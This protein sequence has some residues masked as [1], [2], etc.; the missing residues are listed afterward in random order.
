MADEEVGTKTNKKTQ[1]GRDVYKTSDGEM[2]SEKSITFEVDG[3][4]VNIP[5]IHDGVRYSDDEVYRKFMAGE[6]QP[7]SAHQT[8]EEAITAAKERSK[9]LKF[10]KGGTPMNRQMELFARGGL[11][12]EGGMIDE[13]SGNKVP[14][15]GTR[16]GVRDDIEANVSEGEFIFPEDVTRYI[17]L[18]KLM[19]LRQEAKMGLKR[20][21]A[22][23]Q[24]GNSDEA[25]MDD[26]LPFGMDD[27]IIVAGDSGNDGELNMAVG[28]LTTGTTNVTRTPDPVATVANNPVLPATTTGVRRLTPEI[29]QPVRT[30]VDFKKFMGE[31]S[32]EYKEYRNANGQNILI[33]FL[34]GKAMF[35]IP[36]GYSLYTGDGSIGTGTTPVDDIVADANIATQ[37][38]RTSRGDRNDVSQPQPKAID[39]DN[40]S[41]EELLKLAQDQT[42]TKGTIAKIA[43]AFM[44]PLAIFGYAAMSH[45]SKK[46]LQTINSRI[47]SGAIDSSLKDQY[48][49]VIG[50]LEEG[51]GGLIGGAIDFVGNLLGKKPEEVEEA[52]VKT[53]QIET[54]V[55]NDTGDLLNNILGQTPSV[56]RTAG[57]ASD[58]GESYVPTDQLAVSQRETPDP[59]SLASSEK[60]RF[61]PAPQTADDGYTSLPIAGADGPT[62]YE[63]SLENQSPAAQEARAS[64]YDYTGMQRPATGPDPMIQPYVTPSVQRADPLINTPTI[65]YTTPSGTLP[66]MQSVVNQ[67]NT[68]LNQRNTALNT[69]PDPTIGKTD[70]YQK[71]SFTPDESG[72]YR[73]VGSFPEYKNAGDPAL[74]LGLPPTVAEQT[75]SAFPKYTPPSVSGVAS[76]KPD[77]TQT[78]QSGFGVTPP[79]FAQTADDGYSPVQGQDQYTLASKEGDRFTKPAGT[80]TETAPLDITETAN[81]DITKTE[82]EKVVKADLGTKVIKPKVKYK[83]GQSNQATAWENL[84]DTNLDQAYG[85]S[86]QFKNMGGTTVDNYAVGAISDGTTTGIL[87]DDQG[88]AIRAKNGRN[89]FVDEQGEYHRATIGEL[90][91]NGPKFKQRNVG[92]YDKNKISIASTDR[93]S[94]VTAARKNELSPASKAKIGTDASGGDPNMKGAVW[95]NQPG[96]NVLTRRFPTA[97]ERKK[98]KDDQAKQARIEKT[99][100]AVADKKAADDRI[101]AESIRRANEAYAQQQAAKVAQSSSSSS[102]DRR[103]K[104]QQ[105]AQASATR[106]TKSAISRNAG[107]DGKV[108]KDTYR[109]GGF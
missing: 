56:N 42:G 4:F 25:T 101:R 103:K 12:D 85:L 64:S 22:M 46:I 29:T 47:A 91:K 9:S 59:Y 20:M 104:Q 54:D 1:A 106:Y 109:G 93:V 79:T 90:I 37:E 98:I 16:E 88:Y 14:V 83:T 19:Q 49:E 108:T 6:I 48:N 2:V 43:M 8:K 94:T 50:L 57:A 97:A 23:G 36:E 77:A 11:N 40:I 15:G 69:L 65:D 100:K 62:P 26:D 21:E 35:S 99:R 41:N 80:D 17:G 95:Y 84:P 105:Q 66:F 60:D 34:D 75:A 32:I 39:Y 73:A 3:L 13:E 33:P 74:G 86:Q 44:G 5:S 82:P 96:T 31:A 27:L 58:Y 72:I 70:D 68:A 28:G 107:S 92:D 7:T 63:L 78:P 18:D 61:L 24:M 30:T 102:R 45:Q 81:L 67:R 52:K 53:T 87:A 10:N 89:V 55:Q 71:F 76:Y 51:S 38:V